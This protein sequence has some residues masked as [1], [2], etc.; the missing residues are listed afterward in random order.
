MANGVS[1]TLKNGAFTTADSG[2]PINRAALQSRGNLVLEGVTLGGG[3]VQNL[4]QVEDGFLTMDSCTASSS[5]QGTDAALISIDGANTEATLTHCAFEI[6]NNSVALHITA[7][8]NQVHISDCTV[9]GQ[10][11]EVE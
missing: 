7:P 6:G 1:F 11:M 8:T 10:P 3:G 9:N 2:S 4:V 5:G